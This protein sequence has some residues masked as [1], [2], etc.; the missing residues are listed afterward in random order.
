LEK[1]TNGNTTFKQVEVEKTGSEDGYTTIQQNE[2]LNNQTI[3]VK[4]AYK[5]LAALNKEEEE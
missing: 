3:A 4:G 5:L 1:N 2:V